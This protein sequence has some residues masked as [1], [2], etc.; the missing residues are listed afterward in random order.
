MT[1]T[2]K[3]TAI[4]LVCAVPFG[5]ALRDELRRSEPG[6]ALAAREQ[7]LEAKLAD[8]EQTLEE[9]EAARQ[10][11]A[12]L[13]TRMSPMERPS[14]PLPDDA[15][16]AIIGP[17]PATLGP[18][19]DGVTLGASS[20]DFLPE[21]ARTRIEAF[22]R[23]HP[24]GVDFQ[25]DE[26]ELLSISVNVADPEAVRAALTSRW[27][28]PIGDADPTWLDG[29][30]TKVSLT[31][32]ADR[33]EL[34]AA[35]Y[36]TVEQL[37]APRDPAK[38][39]VEPFPVVGAR[40]ERLVAAL[41]TRLVEDEDVVG[42]YTW[43]T[44]GLPTSDAATVATVVVSDGVISELVVETG[45]YHAD[46]LRAALSAKLGQPT[47]QDSSPWWKAKWSGKRPIEATLHD[48]GARIATHL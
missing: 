7:A 37:I 16:A 3:L 34:R 41:G 38:L 8:L 2:L 21:S 42:R 6:D 48:L 25:F 33:A 1:S 13:L 44:H 4:A 26:R 12:D 32:L 40:I 24:V 10:N 36:Q 43:R 15:L 29:R 46:E 19:F 14:R 22:K 5:L 18:L 23:S 30:G 17:D 9:A 27:G 11:R 39:G 31:P 28:E 45:G 47:E 20:Q 35:R